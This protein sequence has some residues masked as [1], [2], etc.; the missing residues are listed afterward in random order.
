MSQV[1]ASRLD[2]TSGNLHSNNGAPYHFTAASQEA[3]IRRVFGLPE[4]SPLPSVCERT[5]AEYHDYLKTHL[6][7]PFEGLFCQN[8]GEMRQLIHYVQVIELI[9]PRHARNPSLHGLLCRAQNH[10]NILEV[11]LAEFGVREESPNCQLLDD[12]AYWFVNCHS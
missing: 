7:I 9:D 10:R 2:A 12:Y 11:P 5:L 6:A 1:N 8:G 4:E 3:R